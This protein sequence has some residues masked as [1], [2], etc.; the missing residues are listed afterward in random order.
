[1]QEQQ[2]ALNPHQSSKHPDTEAL[3]VALR[4]YKDF[5][6]RVLSL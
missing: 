2:H 3:R 4:Q 6:E 1:L 5:L